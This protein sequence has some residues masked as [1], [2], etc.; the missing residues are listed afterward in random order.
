MGADKNSPQKDEL[1]YGPISTP[2]PSTRDGECNRQ[3]H[4]VTMDLP[5]LGVIVGSTSRSTN[6]GT[7]KHIQFCEPEWT[8][9]QGGADCPRE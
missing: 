2:N 5:T 4:V 6:Q 7:I 3:G 9:C 1:D 8:V